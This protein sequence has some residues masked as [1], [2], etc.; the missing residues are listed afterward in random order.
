MQV[1]VARTGKIL[2][3]DEAG[4]FIKVIDDKADS[5]GFLIL[6]SAT[7]TF[8]SVFDNWVDSHDALVGYFLEAGWKIEWL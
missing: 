4:W 8:T 2:A 3:G 7:P 6:T 1:P 5:G